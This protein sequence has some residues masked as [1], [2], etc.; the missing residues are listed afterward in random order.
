M[1]VALV[2]AI[3][4]ICYVF[5]MP[6]TEAINVKDAI[7]SAVDKQKVDPARKEQLRIQLALNDFQ[8]KNGKLPDKLDELVPT[9]F[10]SVPK[11]PESGDPFQYTIKNGRAVV[12]DATQ[13][14]SA[15]STKDQK[16]KANTIIPA[17]GDDIVELPPLVQKA[18]LESMTNPELSNEP[19]FVY[20]P[21]GKRDPF[22]PFDF[23]PNLDG[24]TTRTPLEKYDIN[25]LKLTAIIAGIGSEATATVENQAGKGFVIKKGTKI[26]LNRGEVIEIQA[27]K[28]L[29]L[30]T[31]TDFT[32]QS[33]TKT[34]ELR[35]RTKDQEERRK[36]V[37]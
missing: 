6:H 16:G 12:G 1:V 2:L 28:V 23:A 11:N 22:R 25:Q 27:D 8:Q 21:T 29:I 31:A 37:Q 3:V 7:Q 30:E 33:K 26:G 4:E 35:L 36:G 5:L 15:K 20:D 17:N 18:L 24:D 14:A 19:P 10:D 9:Y 13:V 34:I 32:G